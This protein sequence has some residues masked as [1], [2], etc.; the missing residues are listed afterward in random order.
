M[1]GKVK[2]VRRYDSSAR[3]RQ[4][5]QNREAILAAAREQF[6]AA[7]YAATSVPAVASAAGVS[8]ETVY[9]AFGPKPAL[10]RAL[11]AQ[12]L[13]GSGSVP[14]E[15]RSDQLSSQADDPVTVIRGWCNLMKE[16]APPTLPILRLVRD[17]AAADPDMSALLA[18]TEQQRRQ[19]MRHNAKRLHSRG[20]LKPGLGVARA[21]DILWTYSSIELYELL[22]LKSGWTVNAYTDFVFDALVSALLPA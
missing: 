1:S 13:G 10:I 9:K 6:L 5:Q 2:T 4:A 14:A 22:V 18:E 12:G 21:G 7:G 19:R 8:A 17:A 15:Q 16:V 3:R 11:W 20:W